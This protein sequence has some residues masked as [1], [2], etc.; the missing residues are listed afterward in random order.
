[1]FSKFESS[2]TSENKI[3]HCLGNL[4]DPSTNVDKIHKNLSILRFSSKYKY[5]IHSLQ[6]WVCRTIN[7]FVPEKNNYT[8]GVPT[9]K[10]KGML[11]GGSLSLK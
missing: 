1:M 3:P 7:V 11:S 5:D 6:V 2:K 10:Y 8:L 4:I 9:S